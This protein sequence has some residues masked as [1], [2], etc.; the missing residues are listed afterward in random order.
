[1]W[2]EGTHAGEPTRGREGRA[3][4]AHGVSVGLGAFRTTMHVL[5]QQYIEFVSEDVATGE[6]YCV[7]HHVSDQTPRSTC[8][9]MYVR[10]LDLFSREAGRWLIDERKLLCDWTEERWLRP[11]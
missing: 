10:Y 7:A 1:V 3:D 2:A 4:L 5:G 6:T 9:T 11:S 8:M